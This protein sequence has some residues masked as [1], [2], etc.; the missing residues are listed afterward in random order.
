MNPEAESRAPSHYLQGNH[1]PDAF[2]ERRYALEFLH[3]TRHPPHLSRQQACEQGNIR[4]IVYK[5]HGLVV[6]DT[7]FFS[8]LI[9]SIEY[10]ARREKYTV[11]ISYINE[12]DGADDRRLLQNQPF[13]GFILLAT[14]MDNK[15]FQ[16]Y[17]QSDKPL[18]VLDNDFN[19]FDTVVINNQQGA[20]EATSYLH[21][22]GHAEIGHLKCSV[23]INNF[24]ERRLGYLKALESFG[25]SGDVKFTFEIGS[26]YETA[27]SDM[28]GALKAQRRIP[29]A[30]F[31]DNDIIALGA[32]KAMQQ[33]GIRIP[34]DV[35][36]V[37]FDDLPLCKIA[38]PS[39]STVRVNKKRLG[40]IA[41]NRLMDK[42]RGNVKGD[43]KIQVGTQIVK[44]ESVRRK[45]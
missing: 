40:S 10:A 1:I 38:E 5:K 7:P 45:N 19:A 42:I 22:M 36:V 2:T 11:T 12:S 35:S 16:L 14:E 31:A 21:D 13:D 23:P 4:F 18:I 30:F 8:E 44:R 29:S 39:L 17:R 20:Y 6:S 34:E 3:D 32:M 37:G 41:M 26:E 33:Y 9:E 15:S 28:L 43:V 25:A 27:Y 24:N